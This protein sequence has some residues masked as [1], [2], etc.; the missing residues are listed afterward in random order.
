[1][2]LHN[3]KPVADKR[4]VVIG[5][6]TGT[7]TVL[8]GL[9]RYPLNL[10]AIVTMADDGG[11]TGVLRDELGVLPPGDVRQCLVALS[12]SDLLMRKLM[13]YRFQNGGLKGHAFGNILLSALEKVTGSFDKAVE[14]ASE[15]LLLEGRVIPAT[16]D[17]VRLSVK[18]QNGKV[19]NGEHNLDLASI[20]ENIRSIRLKPSGQVNPLALRAIQEADMIVVGPGS[21]YSS[22]VPNFLV[23]GLP[24]AICKSRARKVYVCSLMTKKGHTDGWQ[25]HDYAREIEAYVGCS[26]NHI[27]YNSKKPDTHL[28]VRYARKGEGLVEFKKE[29][30]DSRFVGRNL[31]SKKI[32]SLSK[33]DP[34]KRTLI[35]HDSVALGKTILSLL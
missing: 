9:K 20:Q 7:Y 5:G 18:L 17:Q 4:I 8:S 10:S 11:S 3:A 21:F 31:V 30:M 23:R 22:L 15:I 27:I 28:L 2:T 16:L 19:I 32:P 14:K 29:Y 1:M 34:I 24:E 6:G 12:Q 35:R 26:F 33:K 25:A 13:N